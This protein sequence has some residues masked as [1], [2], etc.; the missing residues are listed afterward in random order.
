MKKI[1]DF[2]PEFKNRIDEIS[3]EDIEPNPFNPRKKFSQE[4]E[5]ELIESIAQMKIVLQ[6]I[7]VYEKIRK[8]E[9]K[10][11]ILDGQRR[12][13]ACKKLGID[14]IPAHI[15]VKE[16]TY[17]ENLS[18]MFHIHNVHEDWTDLA[19]STTIPELCRELEIDPQHPTKEGMQNIKK[20]TSL[21][22]YKL[23]KYFDV[24]TYSDEIIKEF[25]EAELKEKPDLDVDILSELKSPLKKIR[26]LMSSS[27]KIEYSKEK[28]VKIIVEKKKNKVITTNKQIRKLS[29]IA[30]NVNRG[31]VNKQVAIERIKDFL[32]N[33]EV[34]IDDI[35]SD[36]SEAIE[37]A[38]GIIKNSEKLRKE[39]DN[40]DL[41]K[42]PNEDKKSLS[43]ELKNLNESIKRKF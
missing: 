24:L 2:M 25:R 12:Y 30:M 8:Q 26:A 35:Y 9:K 33:K 3:I 23:K 29:K 39:I 27:M 16:P 38:K 11:I 18:I 42:L 28:I 21:S 34:T 20:L 17:V 7:I 14:K 13:Q 10:Y 36:T 19:I 43:T 6:P 31:K 4:K 32:D 41:R 1:T 37:Q 15:L 40:I 22:M 5:D